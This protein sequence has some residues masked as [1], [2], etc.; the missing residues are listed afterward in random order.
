MVAV[1]G[2]PHRGPVVSDQLGVVHRDD[3]GLTVEV[4]CGVAA[5]AHDLLHEPV[6]VAERAGGVVDEARLHLS[7]GRVVLLA[8]DGV[9]AAQLQLLAVLLALGQVLLGGAA[10]A[11]VA[12]R[13]VVL[14]AELVLELAR[15]ALTLQTDQ[16]ERRQGDHHDDEDDDDRGAHGGLP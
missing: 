7:P 13:P 12:D 3:V 10:V 5:S 11:T 15:L 16:G 2:Q 4:V 6:G 8:F 9:E 14:G 1:L